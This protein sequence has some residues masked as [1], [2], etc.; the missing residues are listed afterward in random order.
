MST[1]TLTGSEWMAVL[2]IGFGVWWLESWRHKDKRGW[3][4]RGTGISWAASVASEHRWPVVR[5]SFERLV[6]PY[7]RQMAYVVVFAELAIGLGLI[8]GFLTLIA[9]LGACCST[10]CTSR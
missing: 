7:P 10:S 2:R 3:L 5:A 1:Y 6:K 8:L 9:A 4:Q